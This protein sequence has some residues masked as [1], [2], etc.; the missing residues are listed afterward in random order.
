MSEYIRTTFQQIREKVKSMGI[1]EETMRNDCYRNNPQYDNPDKG[2][3]KT[4]Q[5]IYHPSSSDLQEEKLL[6]L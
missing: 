1:S 4:I 5:R 6:G 2:I 3:E